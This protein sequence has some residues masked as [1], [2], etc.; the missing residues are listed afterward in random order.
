MSGWVDG[1]VDGWK[2]GCIVVDG[3]W[4]DGRMDTWG[5]MDAVDASMAAG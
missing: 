2:D 1:S 3:W 4:V 5:W